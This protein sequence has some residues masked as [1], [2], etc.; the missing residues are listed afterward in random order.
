MAELDGAQDLRFG[1]LLRAGFH[2]HDAVFGAGDHDIQ[3]GF[4]AFGVGGIGD[5]LAVL[6]ADAHAGQHVLEGNIGNR[7]R[8]GGADDRQRIRIL[9]GIGRQHHGDDLGFIQETLG[10]QR[11]DRTIDQPAGENLFFGET[12]LA[13]DKAAGNLTGGVSVL[14]VIDGEREKP[15]PRFGLVGHASGDENHRVTGTNDNGAVRLFG[16]L[17]GFQGNLAVAQV[18]FNYVMHSF[19]NLQPRPETSS[20]QL[21]NRRPFRGNRLRLELTGW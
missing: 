17:T 7:Q 18:Y 1:D 6:H 4:A 3:L 5:V 9:L 16:H 21:Q 10:E 11:A 13:F 19:L 12:A 14:A 8:G 20:G 15:G 2:H